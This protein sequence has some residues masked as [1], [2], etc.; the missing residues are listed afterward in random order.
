M[1]RRKKIELCEISFCISIPW[2]L[3]ESRPMFLPLKLALLLP[4]FESIFLPFVEQIGLGTAQVNNFRT[5]VSLQMTSKIIQLNS[6]LRKMK[7][8]DISYI[9][10]LNRALFAVVCIRHARSTAN[11]ASALIR[12]VVAFITNSYQ[13]A[14]AHIGVANDTFAIAF[15]AQTSNG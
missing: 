9:F 6:G 3:S 14:R 15:L 1:R 8:A 12:A 5:S 10:L 2:L 7:S 13:C 11:D 4:L